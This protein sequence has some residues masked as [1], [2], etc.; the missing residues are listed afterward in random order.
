[1]TWETVMRCDRAPAGW[2]CGLEKGHTGP[3][4]AWPK[5]WRHPIWWLRQQGLLP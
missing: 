4:P 3:C 2:T 1:M 5:F